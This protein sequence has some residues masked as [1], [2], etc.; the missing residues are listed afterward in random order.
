MDHGDISIPSIALRIVAVA[1]LNPRRL[2]ASSRTSISTVV[3]R[4]S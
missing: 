4:R 3:M 2:H 1:R